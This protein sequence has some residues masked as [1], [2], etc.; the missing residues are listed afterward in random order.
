MTDVIVHITTDDAWSAAQ[1]TG[2]YRPDSLD[3]EGFI[4]CSTPAQEESP[5]SPSYDEFY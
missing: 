4:H 3:Q 5:L 2:V 1:A